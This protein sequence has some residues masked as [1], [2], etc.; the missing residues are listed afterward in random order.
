[1]SSDPDTNK[2]KK[3]TGGGVKHTHTH[4][5]RVAKAI[6]SSPSLGHSVLRDSGR[7]YDQANE[8]TFDICHMISMWDGED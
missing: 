2:K 5:P 1:M 7:V 4:T 3:R 6:F 8:P